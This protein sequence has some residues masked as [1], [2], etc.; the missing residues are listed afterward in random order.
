MAKEA[1]IQILDALRRDHPEFEADVVRWEPGPDP[2]DFIGTRRDGA[3]IGIELTEWLDPSQ[4]SASIRRTEA[5]Y[6]FWETLNT[7]PSAH[8]CNFS[9]VQ[10]SL[11]DDARLPERDHVALRDEYFRLIARLDVGWGELSLGHP[12]PTWTDFSGYPTVA[13][14][15]SSPLFHTSPLMRRTEGHW[16][17]FEPA[18]GAYTPRWAVLALLS[19]IKTKTRFR[20]LARTYGLA[21]LIL[22]VHYGLKGI[23]HNAPYTGP[24]FGLNDILQQAT[25]L[26]RRN[27]GEFQRVYLYFAF[28]EGPLLQVWPGL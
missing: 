17:I 28:N 11:R 26:L 24:N 22:V 13:K 27:H 16:V 5:Q 25:V 19:R 12:L 1:E 9:V 15:V 14:Y 21:E 3:R 8:P 23:L 4:A 2:P 6:A 7:K 20:G 10:V 18:G